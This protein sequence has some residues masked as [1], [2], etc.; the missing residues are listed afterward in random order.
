[1]LKRLR[2]PY[3]ITVVVWALICATHTVWSLHSY[4]TSPEPFDVYDK[5][6]GFQLAVWTVLGLP[7]WL[8]ILCLAL[9]AVYFLKRNR[10]RVH[11]ATKG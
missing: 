10:R 6:L 9:L 3:G 1:M 2:S 4:L 7:I 5:T 11:D 8:G